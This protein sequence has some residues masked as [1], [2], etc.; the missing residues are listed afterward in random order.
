[1][2]SHN[3]EL[4]DQIAFMSHI[5]YLH[6]HHAVAHC[7][8]LAQDL[9]DMAQSLLRSSHR[10]PNLAPTCSKVEPR[11]PDPRQDLRDGPDLSPDL[12]QDSQDPA[13]PGQT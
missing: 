1:M 11:L 12:S 13:N 4:L 9:G 8:I 7:S 2:T 5:F 10:P 6:P 3:I